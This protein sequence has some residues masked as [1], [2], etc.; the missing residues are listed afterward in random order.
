LTVT[1]QLHGPDD[2]D[3][4][5]YHLQSS[6]SLNATFEGHSVPLV[7]ANDDELFAIYSA[8]IT[9]GSA[10][11]ADEPIVV[12]FDRGGDAVKLTATTTADFA[13]QAPATSAQPVTVSWS[14][15][16]ADR[17]HWDSKSSSVP[18]ADGAIETDSGAITFPPGVLTQ[19]PPE[20]VTIDVARS[21]SSTP[22]TGLQTATVAFNRWHTVMVEVTQ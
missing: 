12:T 14:P 4:V 2:F 5:P 18:S 1:L 9:P 19:Q 15:T 3:G 10:V 13:L 17:I 21:R 6:E 22:L 11:P 8:K 16:A 7:F 20:T